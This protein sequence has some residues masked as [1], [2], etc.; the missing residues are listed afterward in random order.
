M[1]I[2]LVEFDLQPSRTLGNGPSDCVSAR[3]LHHRSHS[4]IVNDRSGAA[5]LCAMHTCVA[6]GT[7]T[8]P[9]APP[10]LQSTD[11]SLSS[12]RTHC[13]PVSAATP[14]AQHQRSSR[15]TY[16]KHVSFRCVIPGTHA[17]H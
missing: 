10:D 9:G 4:M 6:S 1:N 13:A 11:L 16:T 8:L 5:S 14:H 3:P 12:Q 7:A 15:A 17:G 2:Q